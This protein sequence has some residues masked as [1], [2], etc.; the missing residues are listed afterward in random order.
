MFPTGEGQQ[1]AS[2]GGDTAAAPLKEGPD[3]GNA[4]G[5]CA[6]SQR[7]KSHRAVPLLCPAPGQN[8]LSHPKAAA[9]G[10]DTPPCAAPQ[11]VGSATS[12]P[13]LIPQISDQATLWIFCSDLDRCGRAGRGSPQC[14]PHPP[15][16][17]SPQLPA[18]PS[19]HAGILRQP[20]P[21]AAKDPHDNIKRLIKK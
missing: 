13:V 11:A 7:D 9:V 2:P 21:K 14:F 18:L 5:G 16:F 8:L 4:A 15:C 3:E 10:A 19:L 20:H 1:E 12:W 17:P 6:I